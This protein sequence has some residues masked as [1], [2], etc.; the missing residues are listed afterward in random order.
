MPFRDAYREIGE[1][2][3]KNTYTPETDRRHTHEGSIH[4]LCLDKIKDKFPN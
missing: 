4:N 2:V 1:Q 3:Q